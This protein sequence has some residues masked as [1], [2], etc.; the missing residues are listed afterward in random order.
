VE[1]ER[2]RGE[3]REKE[4]LLTQLS[5]VQGELERRGLELN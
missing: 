3:L 5:E 1:L 4:T 2:L